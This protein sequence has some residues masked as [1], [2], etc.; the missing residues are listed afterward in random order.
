MAAVWEHK[1]YTGWGGGRGSTRTRVQEKYKCLYRMFFW[2]FNATGQLI[3]LYHGLNLSMASGL[4][5]NDALLTSAGVQLYYMNFSFTVKTNTFVYL[6]TAAVF[7]CDYMLHTMNQGISENK[8]RLNIPHPF[9]CC[10]CFLEYLLMTLWRPTVWLPVL[11]WAT[12]GTN[13]L[14][15]QACVL[16]CWAS[17]TSP[18]GLHICVV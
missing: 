3:G 18:H 11:H 15:S 1:Q 8:W 14:L 2:T 5:V 17:S 9:V 16:S 4:F 6:M 7:I 12:K 13:G 10:I